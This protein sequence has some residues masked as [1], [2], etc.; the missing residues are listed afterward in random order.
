MTDNLLENACKLLAAKAK[1][2]IATIISQAGSTPRTAGTQMIVME[3][4]TIH[5]TIGGGLLEAKVV[6]KAVE[7]IK[8]RVASVFMPF[9]LTYEDVAS[10]DMICGG[11]AEVFLDNVMPTPENLAAFRLWNKMLQRRKNG[12]FITAIMGDQVYHAV[13]GEEKRSYE[14]LPLSSDALAKIVGE[15]ASVSALKVFKLDEAQ[16]FIE[17]AVRP[18]TA[19]L[20]GA[21]HV[22]KYTAHLCAMTGFYVTI[23]DDRREFANAERFPDAHE[24]HAIDDFENACSGLSINSD[25]FIVIFTRG[26]LHD[27]IVL[28]QALE[29]DA[30]YIGMIG[31]RK[32]RDFIYKA[33]RDLGYK[34]SNLDRVH[35][36]IGLAIGAQTPEEIAVSI[37]AELIQERSK[38]FK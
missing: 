25:T 10:M 31:S 37:V 26:H 16:V 20:F 5:G 27:K 19:L 29:T 28:A 35:S 13:V 3:N 34:Q 18:K 30:S 7:I 38:I 21:G 23:V 32:K 9:D 8:N 4:G 36:P 11:R 12:H 33:L 24:I 6:E 15:T 2:V 22:A 14:H 17:P 1:F